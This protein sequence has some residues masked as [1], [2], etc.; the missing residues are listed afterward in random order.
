MGGLGV[1]VLDGHGVL[2]W[3]F[4]GVGLDAEFLFSRAKEEVENGGN[5]THLTRRH[6]FFQA[7]QEHFVRLQGIE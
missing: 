4:V 6:G 2:V 7:Q 3:A 5:D 1:F